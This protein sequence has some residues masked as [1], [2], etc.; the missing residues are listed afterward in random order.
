MSFR[1]WAYIQYADKDKA[2]SDEDI[3]RQI[4]SLLD[5]N[6]RACFFG[7]DN[8]I[9]RETILRWLDEGMTAD[10]YHGFFLTLI[11]QEIP[12]SVLKETLR[13]LNP[14][15]LHETPYE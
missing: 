11:D 7:G 14:K 4:F 1:E 8:K 15:L 12:G 10:E 2:V 5:H 6:E 13:T 3:A 9:N